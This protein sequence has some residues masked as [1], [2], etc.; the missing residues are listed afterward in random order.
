MLKWWDTYSFPLVASK[1]GS[2]GERHSHMLFWSW[3]E[4]LG[5]GKPPLRP[6]LPHLL[7]RALFMAVLSLRLAS[8]CYGGLL[9]VN[10]TASSVACPTLQP[11][12]STMRYLIPPQWVSLRP[13]KVLDSTR[14]R[15]GI[16]TPERT[17]LRPPVKSWDYYEN[18]VMTSDVK[19]VPWLYPSDISWITEVWLETSPTSALPL[20][21]FRSVTTEM[22]NSR[23]SV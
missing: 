3:G 23:C 15:A 1:N 20:P 11:P 21:V 4:Q 2:S 22:Q 9:N 12:D 10:A 6:P 5:P 16:K 13:P 8:S 19:L 7:L 17:E 18:L 14:V